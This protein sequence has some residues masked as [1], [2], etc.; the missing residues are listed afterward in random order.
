MRRP[1]GSDKGTTP[2]DTSA[3]FTRFYQVDGD[4]FVLRYT[5]AITFNVQYIKLASDTNVVPT[6]ED[7][8]N[9]SLTAENE[10]ETKAR[11]DVL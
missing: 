8:S 10:A 6:S 4:Y 1:I 7:R 2:S 3:N 9:T 11:S 5:E